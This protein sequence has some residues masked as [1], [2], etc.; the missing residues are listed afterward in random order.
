MYQ[1]HAL[2]DIPDRQRFEQIEAAGLRRSCESFGQRAVA[3]GAVYGARTSPGV[4]PRGGGANFF[5]Q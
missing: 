2:S 3:A 4:R 1:P 5:G